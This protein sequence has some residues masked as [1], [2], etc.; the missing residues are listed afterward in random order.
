[1][2]REEAQ[3]ILQSLKESKLPVT[4]EIRKL[5][6][7]NEHVVVLSDGTF[8]WSKNDWKQY[9]KGILPTLKIPRHMILMP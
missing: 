6:G 7:D 4:G 9:K 2:S 1:M 8:L 5:A 3:S